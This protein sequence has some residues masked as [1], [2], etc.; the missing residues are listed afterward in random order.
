MSTG[1]SG[2]PLLGTWTLKSCVL[3]ARTGEK[4]TPYGEHPIGYLGYSADGRMYAIGTSRGRVLPLDSGPTDEERVALYETMFAYAGNYS[5]EEGTVTHHVDVS[6]NE[7]W[8]GTDQ[9]RFYD[10]SENTLTITARVVDST[11]GTEAQYAIGR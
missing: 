2:N 4:S 5:L 9:V 3:T 8:R 6:W 11:N 10:L 1:T 7:E